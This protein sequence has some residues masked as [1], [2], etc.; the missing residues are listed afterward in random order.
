M[1]LDPIFLTRAAE[2]LDRRGFTVSEVEKMAA[3]GVIGAD[4]R[5]DLI[6]GEIVPREPQSL[7][8][9][10]I[11]GH[12]A[13]MMMERSGH[14]VEVTA[15]S[16]VL[17][18]H[19]CFDADV[20]AFR[21]NKTRRYIEPANVLLAVEVAATSRARDLFAKA[22]C[23][24]AAGVPELWVVE[25]NEELTYVFREPGTVAWSQPARVPFS[26]A[27]TPLFLPEASIRLSELI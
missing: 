22:P 7:A 9:V 6:G 10:L 18:D 3:I 14:D 25:L 26:E 20:L 27:L 13:G 12:L 4:D 2:D 5:F 16:I 21:A 1:A 8:H 24:G 11:K 17:D 19:R 23:Y 15:G